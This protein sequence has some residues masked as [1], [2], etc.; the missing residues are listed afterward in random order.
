MSVVYTSYTVVA[1]YSVQELLWTKISG[2]EQTTV[3]SVLFTAQCGGIRLKRS[4]IVILE[5]KGIKW[6]V[7]NNT[8]K[9]ENPDTDK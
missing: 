5:M 2:K 8:Q 7:Q 4:E 3:I 1:D 9:E 6:K